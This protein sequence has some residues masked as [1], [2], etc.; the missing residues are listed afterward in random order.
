MSADLDED[1][2]SRR[3]PGVDDATVEAVGKLSEAL[4]T[5]ERARGA[6][7]TFHQLIGHA[8][9]Q[10]G[11]ACE[12]LRAA[13][14]PTVA[15]ELDHDLVGRNVLSGRWTFQVVDEF[16]DGY[17]SAFRDHESAVRGQLMQGV[18]HVFEAEMKQ[19]RRTVGHPDHDAVPD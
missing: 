18:R 3:P 14:H 11:Q 17:W 10:L 9:L 16:D 5:V 13:G 12:M 1:G 4:E 7:Y 19:S 15:A 2:L 8:D 6:L